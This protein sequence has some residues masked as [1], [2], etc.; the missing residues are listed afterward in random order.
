MSLGFRTKTAL[1]NGSR[2]LLSKPLRHPFLL[3]GLVTLCM[4]V[5]HTALALDPQAPP[6]AVSYTF[7]PPAQTTTP[8][9]DL[10]TSIGQGG[11]SSDGLAGGM[12][13]GGSAATVTQ[14][15]LETLTQ[16]VGGDAMKANELV[17]IMG[18]DASATLAAITS[19]NITQM[20]TQQLGSANAATNF[21]SQIV[22][23]GNA[24]EA[25]SGALGQSGTLNALLGGMGG[26]AAQG[27]A[28]ML[29]GNDSAIASVK[30]LLKG[31]V[32]GLAN[33]DKFLGGDLG[34]LGSLTDALG[35][36]TEML[37]KL[38]GILGPDAVIGELKGILGD[39][40]SAEILKN[41]LG[42]DKAA[43]VL[44]DVLG[45]DVAE[46]LGIDPEAAECG[47]A[48]LTGSFTPDACALTQ[49]N[50]S[51]DYVK[52][53]EAGKLPADQ[54]DILG[55][56]TV[57]AM[58]GQVK[59]ETAGIPDQSR[60]IGSIYDAAAANEAKRQAD[61]QELKALQAMQP[62]AQSCALPSN[63]P[64]LAQ[65]NLVG[66]ALR[67]AMYNDLAKQMNPVKGTTTAKGPLAV[68]SERYD[69]YCNMF[70][71]NESNA[72]V[73]ACAGTPLPDAITRAQ[74]APT[75]G[76]NQNQ[77]QQGQ[78]Q[79]NNAAGDD[80]KKAAEADAEDDAAQQGSAFVPD[81]DIDVE[82][83]LLSDTF[84]I[85]EEPQR[86]AAAAI[87]R[88]IVAP[89]SYPV[90]T[91]EQLNTAA[92]RQWLAR[93]ERIDTV[94]KVA[95]DVVSG[96]IS[97][98]VGIPLPDPVAMGDILPASEMG[99]PT[100]SC[101][102][103]GP[104]KEGNQ[105]AYEKALKIYNDRGSS[106]VKA[107]YTSAGMTY[108]QRYARDAT[109]NY[110]LSQNPRDAK[111]AMERYRSLGL[112]QAMKMSELRPGDMVYLQ[113]RSTN[114]K[115]HGHSGIY[116]GGGK[117]LNVCGRSNG[118]I[119]NSSLQ[120]W[121][122]RNGAAWGYV[123][124]SGRSKETTACPKFEYNKDA[125]GKQIEAGKPTIVTEGPLAGRK[126][127]DT[128]ETPPSGPPAASR[129]SHQQWR[130]ALAQ[131][132]SG[133]GG[134]CH[135]GRKV[136]YSGPTGAGYQCINSLGYIGKFQFGKPALVDGGCSHGGYRMHDCHGQRIR[137]VADFLNN[138]AAQEAA[139]T[140]YTKKNWAYLR[141][142]GVHPSF[143]KTVGGIAF[144]PSGALAGAHLKGAGAVSKWVRGRLGKTTDAY[145]TS[146]T[147][148]I[149]QFGGYQVPFGAAP[150]H[151]GSD[152]GGGYE[153]EETYG[154]SD[155][156]VPP[157]PRPVKELIAEIRQRAGIPEN[158][159]GEDPSYNEIMLALT[160]ERFFDPR[161]YADMADSMAAMK[162]N[163]TTL[164]A[165]ISL[166]LQDIYLLQEQINALTAARASLRL[167]GTEPPV[168]QK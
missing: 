23:T 163:E 132:E 84:D 5:S 164:N 24:V 43:E 106:A 45:E 27:V 58:K 113:S 90:L 19:G 135:N 167:E 115:K 13:N 127:G 52:E 131:R 138:P 75:G 107:R 71:D 126:A 89:K 31:D 16:A 59:Q 114:G 140:Q 35:G 153:G 160:K 137:S 18:G 72:G 145:G 79:Q 46:A 147:S 93:K 102:P 76:A 83:I 39:A 158:E 68:T 122:T 142:K 146:I 134:A 165:Y 85:K 91:E 33:L 51:I 111:E 22:G 32:A 8:A 47:E 80:T 97:R 3:A 62:S 133:G 66:H 28:S 109:N 41:V 96:M 129:G 159:I 30:D 110:A 60:Q 150:C 162:H 40:M 104:A 117:F 50:R 108:C 54:L 64:A 88:N 86:I 17:R 119:C 25:L 20:L 161:Y 98:R 49:D 166:S 123:R 61:V 152:Y 149:T 69:E 78:N 42:A 15:A 55:P 53:R 100:D 14:S 82:N 120:G 99:A 101:Y 7:D 37:S 87:L 136:G 128:S 144:T 116:S 12:F 121:I 94:R 112:L 65:T 103:A 6:P 48:P 36:S 118:V 92:G 105:R 56:K 141:S 157:P 139:M 125:E 81:G 29:L 21:L 168:A 9:P 154:M 74:G 2:N 156:Y 77:N 95:A 73:G 11:S 151:A 44:T 1:N 143:C 130:E 70:F 26:D 10:A 155:V 124:P 148:Y 63:A 34:A 67:R 57:E 4:T 38:T